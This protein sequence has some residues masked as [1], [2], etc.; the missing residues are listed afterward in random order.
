MNK[1][2]EKS[3]EVNITSDVNKPCVI[4]E[5][6]FF[7]LDEWGGFKKGGFYFILFYFLAVLGL[8]C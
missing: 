7:Q 4:S 3:R 2:I 1:Y 6:F 8:R 5:I